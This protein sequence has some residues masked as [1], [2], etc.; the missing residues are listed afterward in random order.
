MTGGKKKKRCLAAMRCHQLSKSGSVNGGGS[1]TLQELAPTSGP[2]KNTALERVEAPS[3]R[4]DS[5]VSTEPHVSPDANLMGCNDICGKQVRSTKTPPN[6]QPGVKDL[7]L[8]LWA[9]HPR[10]ALVFL[11][12]A[13]PAQRLYDCMRR[14]YTFL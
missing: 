9:T 11:V 2:R 12:H 8:M 3:R 13:L 4:R 6:F 10:I 14:T 7:L 5:E 1:S